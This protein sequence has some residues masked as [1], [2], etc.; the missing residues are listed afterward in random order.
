MQVFLQTIVSSIA[1]TEPKESIPTASVYMC[2]AQTNDL[3]DIAKHYSS[4][5]GMIIALNELDE[6]AD[7]VG[8][9]LII[10]RIK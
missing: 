7:I 6:D 1:V 5:I 3:W 10:P 2:M 8:R 4:D 9:L